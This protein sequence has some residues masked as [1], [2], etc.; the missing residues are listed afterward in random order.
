MEIRTPKVPDL[1]EIDEMQEQY[2]NT[3]NKYSNYA[4]MYSTSG[5]GADEFSWDPT[6]GL[7]L[8]IVSTSPISGPK[9]YSPNEQGDSNTSASDKPIDLGKEM[10]G[11]ASEGDYAKYI[12]SMVSDNG[13]YHNILKRVLR[14]DKG[15]SMMM[16]GF[17]NLLARKGIFVQVTEW[18]R[19][20]EPGK[21]ASYHN[22]SRAVDIQ[23]MY[24]E[25]K[26]DL[27]KRI[28]TDEDIVTYM[29]THHIGILDE[30][31]PEN[32]KHY[33]GTGA[34]LLHIGYKNGYEY[35]ERMVDKYKND[36]KHPDVTDEEVIRMWKNENPNLVGKKGD[37][38]VPYNDGHETIGPGLLVSN[39]TKE[40][41][42]QARKGVSLTTLNNWLRNHINEVKKASRDA[43]PN[44][45]QLN[46]GWQR[47]IMDMEYQLGP[48]GFKKFNNLRESLRKNDFEKAKTQIMTY[49]EQN[50]KMV[51]DKRRYE[52]RLKMLQS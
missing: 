6:D 22:N 12:G 46:K 32:K 39:L 7:P 16:G 20:K 13:K 35:F 10:E 14:P 9:P 48:H 1:S 33:H 31:L 38:F 34:G 5:M 23:P 26:D 36:M 11:E 29:K 37:V 15:D 45:D 25:N 24:G 40:Q 21:P 8:N 4:D 27:I 3:A 47:V 28:V 42:A 52:L 2:T 49:F 41:H 44:F 17:L 51:Q 19:R 50:G 18:N 30:Y 43:V